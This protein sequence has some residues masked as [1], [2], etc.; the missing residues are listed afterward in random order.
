M[1]T[2]R[3]G[4][5]RF[6]TL[7]Q[8]LYTFIEGYADLFKS[9]THSYVAKAKQYVSGLFQAEKSNMGTMSDTVKDSVHQNVN[10]FISQSP[11]DARSVIGRIGS[12]TEQELRTV[13]QQTG[14]PIGYLVDESGWRKQGVKSVGVGRQ[15]WG[16]LGNVD[17]GQVAV[18][19]SVVCETERSLINT[20][21]FLPED[22]TKDTT[23]C[24]NAGIPSESRV[25]KTKPMRAFEM[26][27]E[28]RQRGRQF[29]WVGGDGLYGHDSTCRYGL[30][31]DGEQDLLDIHAD[32]E[33]YLTRPQPFV[34]ERQGDRGRHPTRYRVNLNDSPS[35][36]V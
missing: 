8:E 17:N 31:D 32:D 24:D 25:F 28:D 11:W 30:A 9:R 35:T 10:H 7:A 22:W 20:R 36:E 6:E 1:T 13:A 15:Y 23:R 19:G 21:V 14:Q 29:E 26:I 16:S 12:E 4:E 27:R 34:P 18:F 3:E 5:A 2:Q 33:V